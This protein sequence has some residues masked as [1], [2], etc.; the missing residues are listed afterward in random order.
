[1]N[2]HTGAFSFKSLQVSRASGINKMN[3]CDLKGLF[4][5][6]RA[7]TDTHTIRGALF[8]QL[9]LLWRSSRS[10]RPNGSVGISI[11][12][13]PRFTHFFPHMPKYSSRLFCSCLSLLTGGRKAAAIIAAVLCDVLIVCVDSFW[14]LPSDICTF[15]AGV[16]PYVWS[17]WPRPPTTTK[18]SV[19]LKD[20]GL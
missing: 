19:D 1:M 18:K 17:F 7:H 13:P 3:R 12:S 10:K 6:V 4:G 11:S 9:I 20:F 8:M 14:P 2:R 5:C 15:P 16:A